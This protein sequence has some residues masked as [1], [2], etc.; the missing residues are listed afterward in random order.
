MNAPTLRRRRRRPA[1][2]AKLGAT[3]ATA[4]QNM[5]ER[6]DRMIDASMTSGWP[7]KTAKIRFLNLPPAAGPR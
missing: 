3:K 1:Q 7:I 4:A 2:A 6:A 5:L